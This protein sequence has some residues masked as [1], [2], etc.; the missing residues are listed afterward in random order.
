MKLFSILLAITLLGLV[1]AWWH[2]HKSATNSL[3]IENAVMVKAGD[4]TA[5]VA[6]LPPNSSIP[7]ETA[8]APVTKVQPIVEAKDSTTFARWANM[9]STVLY[10]LD[11]ILLLIIITASMRIYAKPLMAAGTRNSKIRRRTRSG[12]QT[13]NIFRLNFKP[14]FQLF[15][16]AIVLS[17]GAGGIFWYK[18]SNIL[19]K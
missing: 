13:D 10:L 17:A 5:M 4:S 19:K 3:P 7:A 6:P 11:L 15:V 12:F 8:P 18:H 16:V 9:D 14:V 1:G 2:S